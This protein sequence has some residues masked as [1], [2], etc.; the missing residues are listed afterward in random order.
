M[1]YKYLLPVLSLTLCGFLLLTS[2]GGSSTGPDNNGQPSTP[3]NLSGTSGDQ[4][5]QLSWDAN[6]EDDLAG[7]N[8]YR[9]TSSFSDIS[10]MDPVNGGNVISNPEFTDTNLKNGTT[11]YY[12]ITAVNNN[13]EESNASS[14]LEITPFSDPPDRP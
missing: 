8:L 11:Y 1:K 14:Q 9:S 12:R 6:S 7:Y 3:K 5:I 2:C 13:D 10:G 4:Q